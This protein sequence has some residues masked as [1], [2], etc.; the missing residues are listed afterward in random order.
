VPRVRDFHYLAQQVS[1][2]QNNLKKAKQVYLNTL[3]VLTV[4]FYLRCMGIKTSYDNC[5]SLNPVIQHLIDIADLDIIGL[6]KIEC[7]P[8]LSEEDIIYPSEENYLEKIGYVVVKL[9]E[10]LLEATILGFVKTIPENSQFFLNQLQSLEE[11][12][13]YLQ[14]LEEI[15]EIA[16]TQ[17]QGEIEDSGQIISLR[18][19]LDNIIDVGWQTVDSIFNP[20]GN[21]PALNF[22]SV[23]N[24]GAIAHRNTSQNISKNPSIPIQQ[25]KL[26]NLG[27]E[28]GKIALIVGITP[29]SSEEM[30]VYV[31]LYPTSGERYLPEQLELIILDDKGIS[32]M[33]ATARS[34]KSIQL[35]F[36]SEFG[37]LFSIQV[38]FGELSFTETFIV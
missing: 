4:N 10:S 37:E 25:G 14:Q 15:K 23:D 16:K 6:G 24:I 9:D 35:N 1:K 27:G 13:I 8:I 12:L 17:R 11:F 3:A 29:V 32:V 26:L 31:K 20:H 33:Q 21:H 19:W 18:G 2:R 36:S 30:N 28:V 7:L 34:T 5:Y 22:R 38:S